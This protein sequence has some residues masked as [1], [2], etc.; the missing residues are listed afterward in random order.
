MFD[1]KIKTFLFYK[2][3]LLLIILS[4]LL[5]LSLLNFILFLAWNTYLNDFPVFLLNHL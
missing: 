5:S 3:L 2:F 4:F 1:L